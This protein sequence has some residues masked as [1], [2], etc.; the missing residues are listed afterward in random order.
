MSTKYERDIYL[1]LSLYRFFAY[2]LA[3]ILIQGVQLDSD[4]GPPFRSYVLLSVVGIYSL[5]KVLGPL[6]WWR[7]D[8][9]TY[10]VLGGDAIASLVVLLLTNGLD[11]PYLLYSLT[12]V[13][14]ASLLFKEK[15]A[16]AGASLFSIAITI[17]H[18]SA[19][20][21]NTSFTSIIEG[22][23][24]LWLILYVTT[25]FVIATSVY[26]TNL[27][28]RRRIES[29]ATQDERG[30]IRREIHDGLAQSLTYLSIKTEAVGKLIAANQ[31]SE[32][33]AALEEVRAIVKDTYDEVRES[34][35]QLAVDPFPLILVL[36]EYVGEAGNRNGFETEFEGPSKP[37]QLPP[38]AE[39]QLL[40]IVQE[41][42]ANIRRHSKAT[43]AWVS[44]DENKRMVEL[45]IRDNGCGFVTNDDAKK[46]GA[47][48]HGLQVMRER[49]ESLGGTL[50]ITTGDQEGTEVRVLLPRRRLRA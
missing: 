29:D 15:L 42:L 49:A 43:K 16:L 39:F 11:S 28:I 22:N 40:R 5:L 23:Y 50:E 10:V 6:R 45:T 21:W 26:R 13:I 24:L 46:N 25:S 1:F 3:V 2:G 12:P 37:L 41:A 19:D 48:H 18:L 35:D 7:Q 47:G 32:A 27:N 30:R 34:I 4:S 36:S 8:S 31:P 17:A 33:H 44:L 20:W 38:A 14:T 9:S